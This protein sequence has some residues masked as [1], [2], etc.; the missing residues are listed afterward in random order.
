MFVFRCLYPQR[1]EAPA[2]Q[3]SG[4]YAHHSAHRCALTPLISLSLRSFRSHSAHFALTHSHS[5]H[6]ALT[7]LS[8]H[9]LSSHC[10]LTSL[11]A[12]T[13]LTQLTAHTVLRLAPG[14]WLTRMELIRTPSRL[15]TVPPLHTE[16][17]LLLLLQ[18]RGYP[19]FRHS[20]ER[21]LN[22]R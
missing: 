21:L 22:E 1:R 13:A 3:A 11:T 19:G 5:A 7:L 16:P 17:L 18:T 2:L 20:P 14:C 12:L 6:G 4:G 8:L 15:P 9:A 10:A